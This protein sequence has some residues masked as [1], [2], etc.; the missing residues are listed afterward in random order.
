MLSLP[1][2]DATGGRVGAVSRIERTRASCAAGD[3]LHILIAGATP[4]R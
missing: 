3:N 1:R 2:D 4:G